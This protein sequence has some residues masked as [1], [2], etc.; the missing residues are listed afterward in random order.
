MN[1]ERHGG[2]LWLEMGALKAED[3]VGNKLELDN[4]VASPEL[5]DRVMPNVEEGM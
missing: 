2:G 4:E 5:S 1:F 3:E